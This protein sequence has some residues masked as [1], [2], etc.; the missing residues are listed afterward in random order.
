MSS[1]T[2]TLFHSNIGIGEAVGDAIVGYC[3]VFLMLAIL[4]VVIQIISKVLKAVTKED[5]Q[6]AAAAVAEA[7]PAPAPEP[8]KAPGSAGELILKDVSDRDA[9]M[10]MAI[11][12]DTLGKPVNTLHFKSIRKVDKEEQ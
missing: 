10:I 3:V 9:A 11:V 8:E 2:F 12:A 6:P 1:S 5:A 7:A 4:I